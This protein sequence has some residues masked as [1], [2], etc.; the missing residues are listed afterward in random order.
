ME[1]QEDTQRSVCTPCTEAL[2]KKWEVNSL[3]NS[4][5]QYLHL[6]GTQ[7][8]MLVQTDCK[9]GKMHPMKYFLEWNFLAPQHTKQA[10]HVR[11]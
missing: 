8:Q 11:W 4:Q 3:W 5:G 1:L 2:S 6:E 9:K 7:G 10:F